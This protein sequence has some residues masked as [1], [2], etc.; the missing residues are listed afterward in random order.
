[1]RIQCV[2]MRIKGALNRQYFNHLVDITEMVFK[3][4]INLFI[5]ITCV[6]YAYCVRIILRYIQNILWFVQYH[7]LLH[8]DMRLL[9]LP[10]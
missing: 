5:R 4:I 10:L 8:F 1:M 7:H 2:L 6:L 9:H 3:A